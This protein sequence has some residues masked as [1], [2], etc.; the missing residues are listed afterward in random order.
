MELKNGQGKR[1]AWS[2]LPKQEGT[3]AP[4]SSQEY[5]LRSEEF[6][7]KEVLFTGTT[8]TGKTE[9]AVVHPLMFIGMG[10]GANLK[11]LFVK[12]THG[13]MDEI[14]NK[15]KILY[16][17]LCPGA[18]FYNEKGAKRWVFPTGEEIHFKLLDSLETY[19]S[20]HHGS[21]Y[22]KIYWDELTTFDF[23]LYEIMKTR[24]RFVPKRHDI[25]TV[26]TQM[27]CTTNPWG[28]S[29]DEVY[30]YFIRGK[31]YSVPT[32]IET[33]MKDRKTGKFKTVKTKRM[34]IFA[35]WEENI[36]LED[37]YIASMMEWEI[38]DPMKF[39]ALVQ[40]R[41]DTTIGGM[42]EKLWDETKVKIQDFPIPSGGYCFRSMDWGMS[43][44]YS[45]SYWYEC[46]GDEDLLIN[47]KIENPPAGTLI[48]FGEL[49]GGTIEK[50]DVGFDLTASQVAQKIKEKE[51]F[52][53]ENCFDG[54]QKPHISIG[55]A[56]TQIW[57]KVGTE[58]T[59]YDEFKDEG[60]K[61]K[62]CKKGAGSRVA[63]IQR[64]KQ[65]LNNTNKRDPKRPWFLVFESC[66]HFFNNV[67]NLQRSERDN[68]DVK[69]C[70]HKMD[71][72]RYAIN[73]KKSKTSF[74]SAL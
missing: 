27:I 33:R 31:E 46:G 38:T 4:F 58:M 64:F 68:D 57:N 47:G 17:D 20:L 26:M 62:K 16:P 74:G 19:N 56:D 7:I 25:P 51:K 10:H 72:V 40:G 13:S 5:F 44:P 36:F 8:A 9:T 43:D 15:T 2:P 34:A 14:I 3:A 30:N 53:I 29:K 52:L 12:P 24:L 59:I 37:S 63:G 11:F 21:Q 49:Y 50:P 45:I 48:L 42:F 55:P 70:D 41:W 23:S 28:K 61:W 18:K 54:V 22:C 6:G 60:V 67:P 65:L 32:E 35:S 71:D 73:W 69:G 1:I 66:E 39:R